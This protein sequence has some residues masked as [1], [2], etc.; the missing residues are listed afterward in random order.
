M[1]LTG[2]VFIYVPL[3]FKYKKN[4]DFTIIK[5]VSTMY[6]NVSILS[7]VYLLILLV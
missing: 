2:L 7:I 1:I 6:A 3:Q 5:E 4:Y